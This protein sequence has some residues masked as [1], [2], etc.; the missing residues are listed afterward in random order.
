MI[1]ARHH[2][3]RTRT[4]YEAFLSCV[5]GVFLVTWAVPQAEV[6]DR[7]LA[8]VNGSVITLS[9]VTA[10]RELGRVPAGSAA[11][12]VR[13]ALSSLIDRALELSEVDRYAPPEP[14]AA[15]I[16]REVG[17][18]RARFSNETAFEAALARSGVDLQRLREALRDD[19]RI[20]AYLDQRFAAAD[21]RRQL[22][23][24]DWL[25]GLRR[26]AEL[27]DLYLSER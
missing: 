3:T 23:I 20:Q 1:R 2:D 14:T 26:R 13:A 19:L 21:N 24:A 7:V 25:A 12:P 27:T 9:D 5:A 6:I 18:V 16:E 17:A 4:A 10:A 8:V 15:A 22:L 11:D